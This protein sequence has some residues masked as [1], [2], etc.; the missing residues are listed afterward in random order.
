MQTAEAELARAGKAILMCTVHPENHFSLENVL[1]QGY[2]ICKTV[3]MY[4]SIRHVLRKN[5]E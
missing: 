1:S 2:T 3:P 4:G 5:I